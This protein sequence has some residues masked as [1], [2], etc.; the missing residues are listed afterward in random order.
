MPPKTSAKGGPASGGKTSKGPHGKILAFWSFSEFPQY[1]RSAGWYFTFGI[2]TSILI[3]YT[4][5]TKNFLF[6]V[7][8]IMFTLIIFLHSTK[9][10]DKVSLAITEDGL[11]VG[12]NFYLY[13][14]IKKFWII[15][16]PPDVKNLY[17]D[18]KGLRPTL[19]IPLENKN[20]VQIRK[21]LL[22]Y[23]DEDLEKEDES[24]SE[25]LGR[26]LKI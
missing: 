17:F 5:F 24:L 3:L 18:F 10:P 11:E 2:M 6:G 8:I 4:I 12:N 7:I 16:E 20:P 23:L 22:D 14:E 15:Y 26:K 1:S 19:I 21:I 13:K 25:Y 9:K